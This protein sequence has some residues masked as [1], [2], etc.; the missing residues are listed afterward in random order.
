MRIGVLGGTGRMGRGLAKAW[1]K[2]GHEIILG[3]RDPDR[4]RRIAATIAQETSGQVRGADLET[5]ARDGEVVVLSLPYRAC[6]DWLQRLRDALRGKIIV[7]ITNPF[8]AVPAGQTS[9]VEENAKALGVPARWVAAFKTNFWTTLDQ[10]LNKDGIVRDCFYCGDDRDAKK[11]VAELIAQ[12]GYRPVDCGD[13]TAARTLDLMVP[14]MIDLDRRFGGNA[15][16]SWK[17]LD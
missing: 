12:V 11:V 9:G 6:A 2:A 16:C 17:L 14:L 8:A 7:D 4:A 5:A 13:L 10:P 15:Q 1:A 3:S